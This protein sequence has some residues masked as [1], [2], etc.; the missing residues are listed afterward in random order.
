MALYD[1]YRV[2]LLL[3][4]YKEIK[5]ISHLSLLSKD[6]M[7]NYLA[8][9]CP[10]CQSEDI[11]LFV[12]LPLGV[13]GRQNHSLLYFD[14]KKVDIDAL[15]KRKDVLDDTL[16][17]FLSV[18]WNFCNI[19]NNASLAISFSSEHTLEYYSKYYRREWGSEPNRKNTKIL[20]GKY[21]SSLLSKKSKILEIGSAEGFSAEFLARKGHDVFVLEP[22]GQF[23]EKL[24][25]SYNFKYIDNI[26]TV[27]D[28]FDAI[29]LHH[30]LEHIPDPIGYIRTLS[31]FLKSDGILLIQVPDL[32]LQLGILRK[33]MK[34]NIFAIF[35]CPNYFF[36]EQSK[37][38][39]FPWF[40]ALANDHVSAFTPKG[41][42]YILNESNM[43]IIDII[44]ST[45]D[46]ITYNPEKFAYP[47]DEI[48]GNTPNGIT[49]L[50][51][52]L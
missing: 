44:R 9:R 29:Y 2:F 23:K 19:C 38:E 51:K 41:L 6:N 13:P 27:G 28:V 52:K 14:Y 1:I 47:I 31:V 22:S 37:E 49:L 7:E 11:H 18:P 15:L 26:N 24:R 46:R 33:I 5:E 16:G 35:N 40:D 3:K 20:H 10:I 34:R 43:D 17:F 4:N 45:P 48:T 8:K 25:R 39:S 36:Y 21:L 30:V 32:S 12:K 42:Q 50:A